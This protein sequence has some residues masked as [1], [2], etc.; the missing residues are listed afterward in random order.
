[1]L[2]P[3]LDP[4]PMG[5]KHRAFFLGEHERAV[6]DRFGTRGATVW[7]DGRVVGGWAQRKDGEVVYRLLEDTGSRGAGPRLPPP[8]R[9]SSIGSVIC[10]LRPLPLPAQPG[11]TAFSVSRR[12]VELHTNSL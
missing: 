9:M 5:W 8:L 11:A 3:S 7:W 2:L 10:G 4:T 12:Y 1:M 6:F